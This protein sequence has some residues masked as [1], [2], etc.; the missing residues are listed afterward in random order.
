MIIITFMNNMSLLTIKK[1][2]LVRMIQDHHARL[3]EVEE[4]AALVVAAVVIH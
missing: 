3:A 1:N 4:M 2:S